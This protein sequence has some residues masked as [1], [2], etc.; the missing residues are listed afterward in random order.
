MLFLAGPSDC[1]LRQNKKK[2]R[3]ETPLIVD[4]DHFD[5]YAFTSK[6]EADD[7]KPQGPNNPQPDVVIP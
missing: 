7:K 5:K 2:R 3:N 6:N 4:H 1:D